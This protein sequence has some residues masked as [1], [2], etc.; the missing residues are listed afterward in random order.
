METTNSVNDIVNITGVTGSYPGKPDALRQGGYIFTPHKATKDFISAV[1]GQPIAKGSQY[2][3]VVKGGGGLS[4]TTHPDR[5]HLNEV[6]DYLT[7]CGI[8]E[9]IVV[10]NIEYREPDAVQERAGKELWKRLLG[11]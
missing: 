2:Y 11:D 8:A 3:A 9:P 5:I 4:W 1:S 6:N 10:V 7:K